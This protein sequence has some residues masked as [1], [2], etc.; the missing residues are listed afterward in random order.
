LEICDLA[1]LLDHKFQ[2]KFDEEG[3]DLDLL[4]QEIIRE[5]GEL[6]DELCPDGVPILG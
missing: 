2:I 3:P 6:S 1:K 4:R 5:F